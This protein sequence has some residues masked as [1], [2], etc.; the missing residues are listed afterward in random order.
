M[1][2]K[3][4]LVSYTFWIILAVIVLVI[5]LGAYFFLGDKGISFIDYI[6]NLIRF[7]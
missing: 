5:G 3:G 1:K 4:V 7:G 6:K 2:R